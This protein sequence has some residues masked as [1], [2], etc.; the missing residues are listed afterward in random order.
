MF[1]ALTH[2]DAQQH[3]AS[4][5]V[6]TA[7]RHKLREKSSE[8]MRLSLRKKDTPLQHEDLHSVAGMESE[9]KFVVSVEQYIA[10][11]AAMASRSKDADNSG[12]SFLDVSCHSLRP[13]AV[14]PSK[15]YTQQLRTMSRT[16]LEAF[17][18]MCFEKYERSVQ[19]YALKHHSF[20]LS[21][22]RNRVLAGSSTPLFLIFGERISLQC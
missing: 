16:T 15:H 5:Q 10:E 1:K 7:S 18:D 22:E 13:F 2:N 12:E 17:I 14:E 21:R 3:L 20:Q 4:S 9:R 11:K 6:T 8:L 19:F